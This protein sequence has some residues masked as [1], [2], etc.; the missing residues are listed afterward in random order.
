[1]IGIRADA[2]KIIAT[3]HVMRCITIAR[4]IIALGEAVTFFVADEESRDLIAGYAGDLE[5]CEVVVLGSSYD[6]MEDELPALGKEL[7][8]RNVD[9]LLVDSYFVTHRYFEEIGKICQVV[10]MD[11]LGKEPYPV[12]ILINYS[13]YYKALGYEALYQD[14]KG[15]KGSP[16][17]LLLGLEYAPLRRQFYESTAKGEASEADDRLHVLLTAGG[18]D[19]HGML[20]ATLKAA[21]NA[22]LLAAQFTWE[23]VVGSLVGD[24]DAIDA[25]AGNYSNIRIHRS[26]TN[27]AD[28]MRSCDIAIAAA[29]TMLTEC[30]AIHLPAIFYQVAD[31]Q[32]FNV[33]FWQTNGGMIFA[34]DV[35]SA[36]QDGSGKETT[37]ENICAFLNDIKVNISRLDDMK[38]ALSGLTDG[39]GAIKIAKE[40]ISMEEEAK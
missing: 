18:A 27:M 38:S 33:E 34:G 30:A 9:V 17:R 6:H 28:L 40:L 23:V 35:T 31:N 25:L 20:L 16:T 4:E 29:G 21:E 3:G 26:V 5:A 8:A 12:D 10:Y 14:M 15:H 13:G 39:R 24:A 19:M 7:M 37:L 2:N 1:M 11:D 32:K 22:G 36:N